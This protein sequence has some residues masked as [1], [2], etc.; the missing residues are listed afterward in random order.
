M[1]KLLKFM[2]T[3][4]KFKRLILIAAFVFPVLSIVFGV[5]YQPDYTF[6]CLWIAFYSCLLVCICY[7]TKGLKVFVCCMNAIFVAAFILFFLMG[8]AEIIPGSLWQM[9]LP[10]ITNPWKIC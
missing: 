7:E 8:G 3:N 10:F 4:T 1:K 6:K 2:K 9:V 5:R